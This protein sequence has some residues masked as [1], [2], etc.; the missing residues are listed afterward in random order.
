MKT[1]FNI[2]IA[3]FMLA[4][5][6]PVTFSQKIDGWFKVGSKPEAYEWGKADEKYN[7]GAVYFLK[8]KE[9]AI[10]GFGTMVEQ[11]AIQHRWQ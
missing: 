8:S 9:P 4:V 2:L 7:N 5:F 1:T 11:V 3:L 10:N 6:V